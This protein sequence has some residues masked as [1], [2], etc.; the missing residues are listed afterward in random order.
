MVVYGRIGP[1]NDNNTGG[2]F[3]L[4]TKKIWTI[5]KMATKIGKNNIGMFLS[6]IHNLVTAEWKGLGTCLLACN[7]MWLYD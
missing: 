5:F 4:W 3:Y 7:L 1:N 2:F 6:K